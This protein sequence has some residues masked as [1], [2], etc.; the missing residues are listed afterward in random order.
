M[1][2]RSYNRETTKGMVGTTIFAYF[3]N[4]S[5]NSSFFTF[6]IWI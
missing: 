1:K 2:Y 6:K 3:L 5:L 4:N